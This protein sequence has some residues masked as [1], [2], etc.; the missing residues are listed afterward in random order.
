MHKIVTSI[1]ALLVLGS[2]LAPAR[3]LPAD[4]RVLIE[5]FQAHRR[6]A[7]GYLRTQNGDLAAVEIE[8]LRDKLA[9]DHRALSPAT[10]ADAAA[11]A[12][13]S[14]SAAAVAES[15]K[16]ADSGDLDR[17]RTLL[18]GA[19]ASLDAWRRANGVRMFSDCIAEISAA[20]EP[21]DFFRVNSPELS[22]P[23]MVER[24]VGAS[25]RAMAALDRCD[26]EAAEDVR[27][28]PEFRRLFDGMRASLQQVPDAVAARDG[29]MLHRLL[30]EQRSFEQLLA[31]RFG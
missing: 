14:E 27:R 30:I 21:L 28:E 31:F 29:A 6:V 26:R 16:A 13:V 11:A 17:A 23:G 22:Q 2:G 9:G 5:D 12:A 19:G 8:R 20:Y 25:G 24:I 18:Q 1:A 4:L 3:D 7:L 15:L 10:L